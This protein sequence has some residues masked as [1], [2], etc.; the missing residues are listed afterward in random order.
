[1]QLPYPST[2]NDVFKQMLLV[3]DHTI[4]EWISLREMVAKSLAL[5]DWHNLAAADNMAGTRPFIDK[6]IAPMTS[7][8]QL[9][10]QPIQI[11]NTSKEKLYLPWFAM[12][13]GQ[14]IDISQM[15]R[16]MESLRLV[17]SRRQTASTET[18][19]IDNI[20]WLT[21]DVLDEN[22]LDPD[23][24]TT[25]IHGIRIQD[26]GEEPV[27]MDLGYFWVFVNGRFG[28]GDDSS[29]DM[30][31]K[32]PDRV[33][34]LRFVETLEKLRNEGMLE[35]F[36][37]YRGPGNFGQYYALTSPVRHN[38]VMLASDRYAKGF[39]ILQKQITL[40][41]QDGRKDTM[42]WDDAVRAYFAEPIIL[43]QD[44]E[45]VEKRWKTAKPRITNL[46]RMYVMSSQQGYYI[47]RAMNLETIEAFARGEPIPGIPAN[48]L[49][50]LDLG[51]DI[52]SKYPDLREIARR[53]ILEEVG[54][55]GLT[56]S[57]VM[58]QALLHS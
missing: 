49:E 12:R 11:G 39:Y 19:P 4:L 56:P 15:K 29:D 2:P 47:D 40:D 42:E 35:T 9:R 14:V 1:M 5:G 24:T 41:W 6:L 25:F 58:S 10:S 21:C 48:L 28:I 22:S 27:D 18:P 46:F 45:E 37:P 51:G 7:A 57:Q 31:I 38:T 36:D 8:A 54:P 32:N 30:G 13:S 3:E 26:P 16:F 55:E 34:L 20:L 17:L 53:V 44:R 23:K 43:P 50:S 52:K 33:F